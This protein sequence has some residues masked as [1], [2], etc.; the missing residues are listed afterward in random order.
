[1]PLM[2][3]HTVLPLAALA[4]CAAVLAFG[5]VSTRPAALLQPARFQHHLDAAHAALAEEQKREGMPSHW[6]AAH[7]DEITLDNI[8]REHPSSAWH[9]VL[10]SRTALP[11]K[12][13]RT[14]AKV[15][16]SLS[17]SANTVKFYPLRWMQQQQEPAVF[18]RV[19]QGLAQRRAR[20]TSLWD[21]SANDAAQRQSPWNPAAVNKQIAGWQAGADDQEVKAAGKAAGVYKSARTQKLFIV[22]QANVLTGQGQKQDRHLLTRQGQRKDH[23]STGAPRA[24]GPV[25]AK[26]ASQ[27]QMLSLQTA[28]HPQAAEAAVGAQHSARPVARPLPALF[29]RPVHPLGTR[30]ARTQQLSFAADFLDAPGAGSPRARGNKRPAAATRPAAAA[31]AGGGGEEYGQSGMTRA[32]LSSVRVSFPGDRRR[33]SAGVDGGASAARSRRG[34]GLQGRATQEMLWNAAVDGGR[35]SKWFPALPPK[36]AFG[37][38]L[39]GAYQ[40]Y[41]GGKQMSYIP[42]GVRAH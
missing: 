36:P 7:N 16:R 12:Q 21:A 3:P 39:R 25:H 11:P 24:G 5:R 27:T 10:F 38:P 17:D 4:L 18:S 40:G 8:G 14:R 2:K 31:R 33:G 6:N 19:Q 29:K 1:M 22:P 35:E 20:T 30:A 23:T 9:H 34:A 32:E 28:L 13:V 41:D 42:A 37:V 26:T 15:I